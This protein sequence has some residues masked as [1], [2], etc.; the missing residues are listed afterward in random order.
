MFFMYVCMS[1]ICM[2]GRLRL[3]GR[4][5]LLS[6]FSWRVYSYCAKVLYPTPPVGGWTFA[7]YTIGKPHAYRLWMVVSFIHSLND[8][9]HSHSL[10]QFS[11]QQLQLTSSYCNSLQNFVVVGSC[12]EQLLCTTC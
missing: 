5:T 2:E 11:Q 8:S 3:L 1:F 4:L 7:Q 9:I 10:S 12:N 6:P